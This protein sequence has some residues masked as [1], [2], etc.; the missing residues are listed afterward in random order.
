MGRKKTIS[1]VS[2]YVEN[3]GYKLLSDV[4]VGAHTK[5]E[6]LCSENH[7]FN[8]SWSNFKKGNRCPKCNRKNKNKKIFEEFSKHVES[9]GFKLLSNAYIDVYS[10]LEIQCSEG[11]IFKMSYDNF[12]SGQRC[13][14]CAGKNKNILDVRK[15]VES[16]GFKLLSDV[17]I[18]SKEKLEIQCS[19]GHIFWINWN[20]FQQGK[21]C[22]YCKCS[23]G[24]KRVSEVLK[25]LNLE[26][27]KQKRFIG[28]RNKYT[29]PFDF[30]IPSINILIEYDGRQHFNPVSF[31]DDQTQET[32]NNNLITVLIND[33][34][35]N[36][37]TDENKIKLLRIPY[38][39]FKN[40][41]FIIEEFINKSI[42]K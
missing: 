3:V 18:N 29:L 19:E 8:V 27:E 39:E 37:F 34:I 6:M 42:F 21:R 41:Q 5:L 31:S 25:N 14:K 23:K 24:E 11:H 15:Y 35:K 17:Y 40:I 36:R 2:K 26:F 22:Q 13:P 38:T 7:I 32:K 9:Q 16:Q 33:E 30:Y 12:K 28:C 1:E 20:H 4:Y 10:K